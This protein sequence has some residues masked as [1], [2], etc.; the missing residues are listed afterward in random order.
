MEKVQI[1]TAKGKESNLVISKEVSILDQPIGETRQTKKDAKKAAKEDAVDDLAYHALLSFG[2][3]RWIGYNEWFEV[4]KTG[5]GKL[6]LG[7]DT[8]NAARD[9]LMAAGRVRKS[10]PEGLYQVVLG[11]DGKGSTEDSEASPQSSPSPD[12]PTPGTP[13]SWIY[14]DPG[15]S[16]VGV[17]PGSTPRSARSNSTGDGTE[18]NSAGP[19]AATDAVDQLLKG[20]KG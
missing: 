5:R 16:G 17:N 8:F 4:T 14:R 7:N 2:P 13:D 1:V 18:Q 9:R 20:K 11:A 12:N 19:D 10:F 15:V 3:Q 6:G